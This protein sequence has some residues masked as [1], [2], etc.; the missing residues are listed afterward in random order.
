MDILDDGLTHNKNQ[1]VKSPGGEIDFL[2]LWVVIWNGRWFVVGVTSFCAL[3]SL[4]YAFSLPNIYSS[5]GVYASVQK[6][7]VGGGLAAQYG[8][9][10]AMAGIKLG[11]G[12]NDVSQAL[13]LIRSWPFLEH[14]VEKY[15]LAPFIMAV[16]KWDPASSTILWDRDI[17][18]PELK[19]WNRTSSGKSSFEQPSSFE[20]Y[21]AFNKMIVASSDPKTGLI[22]VG[23]KYHVPELTAHWASLLVLEINEHFQRRDMQDAQRN[24]EYLT[25]KIEETSV[26]EMKSVFYGMI[27]S[28]T[29]TLMLAEVSD[30]Y[31]LKTVI[32]PKVAEQKIMP[33]RSLLLV[34][35]CLFGGFLSTALVLARHYLAKN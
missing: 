14:F 12:N 35:G 27:E 23:V 21:K 24:I 16:K 2:Q 13:A 9:L 1:I 34:L 11:G 22:T 5:N 7:A 28:Q 15:S 25:A 6:D 17:Y 32:S 30:Q 33:N 31:L 18:N 3:I 19:R 20:V 29:K 10:A 4:L 26:A 8:G